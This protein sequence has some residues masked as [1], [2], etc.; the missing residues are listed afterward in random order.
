MPRILDG[1]ARG[2][3]PATRSVPLLFVA[4]IASGCGG[5]LPS[6]TPGASATEG[7]AARAPLATSS[8]AMPRLG[9]T[10]RVG[11]PHEGENGPFTMTYPDPQTG[12]DFIDPI[13]R[14]CLT[15]TL[16]SYNGQ[17]TDKGGAELR[18]DL[19]TD[20]PEVSADGLVWT[21]RIRSGLHYAPPHQDHEIVSGDFVR[22]LERLVRLHGP[23]AYALASIEGL[24]A[25]ASGRAGTIAGLATPDPHTLV[26][27]VSQSV[28]D[29]GYAFAFTMTAPIPPGAADGHDADY[30]HH[31]AASG[32][33]M[34]APDSGSGRPGQAPIALVRSPAWDRA[35]DPLRGAWVDR[36]ELRETGSAAD[37][38]ALLA[39][40][41]LDLGAY[42][43]T[44]EQVAT[45]QA[46]A[47]LRGLVGYAID[48]STV[49]LPLNLATPPFDDPNVRRAIN[50]VLDRA[51][52]AGAWAAATDNPA[53]R[54]AHHAIPDNLEENLL[55]TYDPY[56]S[57]ADAGDVA[58][59]RAAMAR[60]RYD[61][62]RDGRCDAQAC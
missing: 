37:S 11:L 53:P 15:R 9:G 10:L 30:G 19:A 20:L 6:T 31:L 7:S 49:Y 28:G 25:Y 58:A 22:A 62:N 27:R 57:T 16:L 40:G 55:A 26:V 46:D 17:T 34:Y 56:P 51:A 23:I 38:A 21:F 3:S 2:Q 60:S 36:I 35:T 33:Y 5:S 44:A 18:P 41:Q 8:S 45:Y 39:S 12:G 13:L 52:I 50:L 48:S 1:S 32:P 42:A 54:I 14:C 29:L 43:A 61:A 24:D 59:A 4:L 47:A